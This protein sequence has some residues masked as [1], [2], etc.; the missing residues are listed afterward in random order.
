MLRWTLHL[1]IGTVRDNGAHSRVYLYSG[2]TAVAGWAQPECSFCIKLCITTSISSTSTDTGLAA[3]T[4]IGTCNLPF[5]L[6][7]SADG[8]IL[9]TSYGLYPRFTVLLTV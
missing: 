3:L 9:H 6:L 7:L 2:Y 1:A 8:G 4:S 5:S